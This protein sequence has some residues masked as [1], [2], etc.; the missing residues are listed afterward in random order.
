MILPDTIC[1]NEYG[2]YEIQPK[3]TPQALRDYYAQRYYQEN[4]T[5]YLAAYPPEELEHLE[6]KLRLRHYVAEQLRHAGAS[7]SSPAS[8]PAAG[9][10][11]GQTGVVST[12]VAFSEATTR[13]SFLDIGCGEGWALDYFQ[14]QGWDVLGLDFSSY[15]LERFHPALR[16]RL[17]P[18]DLYEGLQT[19][20]AEGRSF[21]VLWLDNVLEHV[22]D[23][24]DLLRRCRALVAP[25][26]VL[27]VDVPNDFSDLQQH[28]L[29]SGHIDRPFWVVLPDHLSY[30][31]QPGLRNLARATGWHTSKVI[32]DQP[33]DLNLLNPNTNYVMNRE[34]G[35]FAHLARLEQDNFLLRTAPLSAVAAYYEGLAG[36]GLGRSI[37]AFLQPA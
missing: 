13:G 4:L 30:F 37:V 2:F 35:K 28:L 9:D 11:S 21:D 15:S 26:G 7:I 33:I 27:V 22:L 36:V 32:G 34:L 19:L 10:A 14:R 8:P 29:E 20:I 3:P 5:T 12:A 31:T 25:R 1:L 17:R 24:A 16:D 23:P 6:G 18:G